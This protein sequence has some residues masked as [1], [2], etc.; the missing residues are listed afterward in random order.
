MTKGL[1]HVWGVLRDFN[2]YSG[3]RF[4]RVFCNSTARGNPVTA[5]LRTLIPVSPLRSISFREPEKGKAMAELVFFH[6]N[7]G[8]RIFLNRDHVLYAEDGSEDGNTLVTLTNGDRVVI[9]DSLPAVRDK[10]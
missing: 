10:H 4:P 6:N 2:N 1:A 8:D 7:S 9:L 3:A 5:S